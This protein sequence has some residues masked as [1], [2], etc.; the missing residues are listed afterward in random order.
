MSQ[1]L[2]KA[3]R[4]IDL[5]ATGHDTLAGLT[6]AADLSRS[7]AHRLLSTLVEHNYLSLAGKHYR[8]GYRLLELGETKKRSLNFLDAL[9]PI[10]MR[11]AQ[12]TGDTIHLAVLDG[13]DIVLIDRVFGDR[14]LRINSYPGL[15]NTAYKTAVG[16]VLLAHLPPKQWKSYLGRI[17]PG[18]R[19]GEEQILAELERARRTNVATDV[20]ECNVGTC[21]IASSF[22]IGDGL[23]VACSINGATVY[24]ADGRLES[25][26]PTVKRLAEELQA[27]TN[28]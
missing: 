3:F 14:Q 19:L 17:P 4:L 22:T 21:G 11:H 25:L 12:E 2:D 26:A 18:Y 5:V 23:R 16:K 6:E 24:F 28:S 13:F 20:D 8:L 9:R 1:V 27:A 7:T 10:L 15:R